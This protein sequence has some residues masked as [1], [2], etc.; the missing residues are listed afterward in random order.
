MKA[1]VSKSGSPAPKPQISWPA[2]FR[3]FA[4]ASTASVGEGTMLR[5]Q[6]D[7]ECAVMDWMND[8]GLLWASS[9]PRVPS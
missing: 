6:V 4:L 9:L 5:A 1:G 7:K 3:L 8:E 2:A